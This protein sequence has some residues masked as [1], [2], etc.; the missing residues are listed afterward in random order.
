MNEYQLATG[1]PADLLI[2]FGSF[3]VCHHFLHSHQSEEKYLPLKLGIGKH[4]GLL[5]LLDKPDWESL[6]PIYPWVICHEPE[7]HLD[8]LVVNLSA[9]LA[10]ESSILGLSS[11]D[12]STLSRL[13]SLGFL[14]VSIFSHPSFANNQNSGVEAV[15]AALSGDTINTDKQYDVIIGRHI[16]EHSWDTRA[17]LNNLLSMLS[18]NGVAVLEVPDNEK[19]FKEFQHTIIWEE[20]SL[21]FTEY[22]LTQLLAKYGLE[23]R[24][25]H[26]YSMALEDILVVELGKQKAS[27]E[28]HSS[29]KEKSMAQEFCQKFSSQKDFFRSKLVEYREQSGEIALLGAGHLG[30]AFINLFGLQDL[31][32]VVIDDDP[33]K[34][35]LFM[36]GSKLP[37]KDSTSLHAGRFRVCLLTCNPWNNDKVKLNHAS[38]TERGGK[39]VS[40]F[41]PEQWS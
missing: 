22:T 12:K 18:E 26:R 10:P 3:P 36:P 30:C 19:A 39:F 25:L 14:N 13:E 40:I 16:L 21:Y 34:Q 24:R 33:N 15:Q 23:V 38:F 35:G 2:D 9:S 8:D 41:Q 4:S 7:E 6:S 31:I 28:Y 1:E 17:F 29:R 37:I 32:D 20:H 27:H 5:G 11:K